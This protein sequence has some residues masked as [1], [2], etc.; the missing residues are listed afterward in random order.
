MRHALLLSRLAV[1]A[2]HE[3]CKVDIQGL[4]NHFVGPRGQAYIDA[5]K[6]NR[7]RWIKPFIGHRGGGSSSAAVAA[8][9]CSDEAHG[10]G[11]DV[12]VG[13]TGLFTVAQRHRDVADEAR[14]VAVSLANA[15][16]RLGDEVSAKIMVEV[17]AVEL[18]N[19]YELDR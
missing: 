4:Y 8:A 2:N 15:F 18:D 17:L 13:R 6:R 1:F 7:G 5:V 19:E 14:C 9:G 10:G 11:G 16:I 3:C 12:D